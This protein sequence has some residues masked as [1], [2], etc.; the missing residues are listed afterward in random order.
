MSVSPPPTGFDSS[1]PVPPS[2]YARMVGGVNVGYDLV[3][4]L[5]ACLLRAL[6]QPNLNLLVVGAGG[7]MEIEQFLPANP[8]WRIVGVDPSEEML[9]LAAIRAGRL[10][11]QNRTALVH[12]VVDDLP[13]ERAFDAAVCLYV[14]HFL[15]DEAK[16]ATL[17]GIGRRLRAEAPLIVA[18]GAR[19]DVDDEDLR[20]DLLGTWQRHGEMMGLPADRMSA[21]IEQILTQNVEATDAKGYLRLLREAGFPRAVSLLNVMNDGMVAWVARR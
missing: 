1:P 18:S 21:T 19:V 13:A 4:R 11:V 3:F 6:Q 20:S 14:L 7:G 15:P 8:G 2:E 16:V 17:Q 9:S 12:G 5:A 10:G